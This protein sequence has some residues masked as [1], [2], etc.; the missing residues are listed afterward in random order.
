ERVGKWNSIGIKLLAGKWGVG[1]LRVKRER[2]G[3]SECTGSLERAGER[4]GADVLFD[5]RAIRAGDAKRWGGRSCDWTGCKPEYR[6]ASGNP[7]ERQ[8]SEWDTL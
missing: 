7:D 3:D 2:D 1:A 4:T 6:A 5:L 8:Q